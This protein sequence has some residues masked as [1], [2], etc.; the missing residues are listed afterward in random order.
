MRTEQENNDK[1]YYHV[2]H[3][4]IHRT[5]AIEMIINEIK[6]LVGVNVMLDIG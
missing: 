3:L 5:C 2:S 6:G 4:Y 1:I